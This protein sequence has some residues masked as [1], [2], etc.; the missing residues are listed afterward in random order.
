VLDAST[1][2]AA[3]ARSGLVDLHLHCGV[4]HAD[5]TGWV[6]GCINHAHDHVC[7]M[8][9]CHTEQLYTD[10]AL[11]LDASTRVAAV[12]RSGLIDLHLHCGVD[13][14]DET[15][16]VAGCIN[17]AHDHV[18]IMSIC[19]TEQLYT[20]AALVLDASTRVAAVARSGLIDLHLHCGVDHADET[21]WVAGCINHAH[22]LAC[23]MSICHTEQLY[24]DAALVLDASTRVA[25]AAG[26]RPHRSVH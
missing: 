5:E 18:C 21:G 7:I 26:K 13:H 24:T 11:V 3:V 20:D 25:A 10:A 2:V 12:A 9:I 16:W 8:S 6:A 19:H 1:R 17:H 14:A 23:I 4:D 22:D 15:G